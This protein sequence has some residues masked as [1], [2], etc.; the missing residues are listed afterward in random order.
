M[1][2]VATIHRLDVLRDRGLSG[3]PADPDA[4]PIAVRAFAIGDLPALGTML[5]RCS[6][7]TLRARTL[8]GSAAAAR[9]ILEELPLRERQAT[10]GA[11]HGQR[12]VGVASLLFTGSRAEIAVLVEDTWQRRGVGTALARSLLDT[13]VHHRVHAVLATVAVTNVG[14]LLVL[15]RSCP[16]AQLSPPRDG[17]LTATWPL[18]P[19]PETA[20]PGFTS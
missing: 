16:G 9:R 10:V 18:T 4:A 7:D 20:S 6:D 19:P 3:A 17:L 1:S 13:A 15:H 12:M 5:S 8:G 2:V 14:A 11:W